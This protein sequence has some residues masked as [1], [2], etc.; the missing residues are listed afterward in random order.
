M[1]VERRFIKGGKLADTRFGH[2]FVL[3]AALVS[4]EE[5][6]EAELGAFLDGARR[7]AEELLE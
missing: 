1:A 3:L 7:L 5:F 6:S 2:Q 4:R